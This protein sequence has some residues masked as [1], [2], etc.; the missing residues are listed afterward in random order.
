LDTERIFL[1]HLKNFS[2]G[3]LKNLPLNKI[4]L[5]HGTVIK[6][7]ITSESVGHEDNDLLTSPTFPISKLS[8]EET[9]VY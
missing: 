5:L 3:H 2:L 6:K 4:I 8:Y 1:G 7:D 9:T